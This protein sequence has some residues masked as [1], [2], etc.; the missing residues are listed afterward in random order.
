MSLSYD[1]V[2]CG[3]LVTTFKGEE[4]CV[5]PTI[6][7]EDNDNKEDKD[8]NNDEN[9]DNDDNDNEEGILDFDLNNVEGM[10]EYELMR[11]Q[12]IRRNESKLTSPH[13]PRSDR[14]HDV[15]QIFHQVQR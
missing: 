9:D 6:D 14:G 12:K 11:L 10:S 1:Q 8:D 2:K 7:E 13:K 3:H 5:S 15:H 4:S